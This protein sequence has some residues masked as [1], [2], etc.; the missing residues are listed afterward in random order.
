MT[1]WRVR[2]IASCSTT[3]SSTLFPLRPWGWR[4]LGRGGGR[5]GFPQPLRPQGGGGKGTAPEVVVQRLNFCRTKPQSKLATPPENIV[6][7]PR[8]FVS[9]QPLDLPLGKVGAKAATQIG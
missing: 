7:G 8:P 5:C 3:R 9:P 1:T 2:P 4:G 6:R